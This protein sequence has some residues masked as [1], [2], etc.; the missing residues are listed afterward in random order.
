MADRKFTLENLN[1]LGLSIEMSY[2]GRRIFRPTFCDS[3]YTFRI[4]RYTVPV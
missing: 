1:F 2:A 4:S 3:R